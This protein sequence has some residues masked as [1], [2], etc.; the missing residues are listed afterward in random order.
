MT[1]MKQALSPEHDQPS[2]RLL[3]KVGR[4]PDSGQLHDARVEPICR[5]YLELRYRMLPYLI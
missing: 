5:K 1:D 3:T 2:A 4:S